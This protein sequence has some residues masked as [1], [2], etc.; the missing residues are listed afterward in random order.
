MGFL[1]AFDRSPE[2]M[3]EG[4]ATLRQELEPQVGQPLQAF[5]LGLS[6]PGAL[7]ATFAGW[8]LSRREHRATGGA[9]DKKGHVGMV[10]VT[11]DGWL[12]VYR[13]RV[14]GGTFRKK[15]TTFEVVEQ[16]RAWPPGHARVRLVRSR[17]QVGIAIDGGEDD[18]LGFEMVADE[19][20]LTHLVQPLA[21]LLGV[22]VEEA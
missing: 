2:A 9:T 13:T 20:A 18:V 6:P 22:V 14:A 4:L 21:A 17:W 3:A 16:V 10:A 1:K 8:G 12:R 15:T 7:E 11:A 5:L 19:A